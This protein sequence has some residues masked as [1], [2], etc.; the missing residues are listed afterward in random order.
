MEVGGQGHKGHPLARIR[1]DRAPLAQVKV[2]QLA[3]FAPLGKEFLGN[4][5]M[6]MGGSSRFDGKFW[7]RL[8][9]DEERRGRGWEFLEPLARIEN[10][11]WVCHG[12]SCH[13]FGNCGESGGKCGANHLSSTGIHH[14]G[15][16]KRDAAKCR[17]EKFGS[18]WEKI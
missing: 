5:A 11:R 2:R 1:A 7:V 12:K 6:Q 3:G 14:P 16:R 15:A 18:E 17:M 9:A 8:I 4:S 13:R 10:S